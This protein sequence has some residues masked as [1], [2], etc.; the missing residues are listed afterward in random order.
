MIKKFQYKEDYKFTYHNLET[1]HRTRIYFGKCSKKEAVERANFIL[2]HYRNKETYFINPHNNNYVVLATLE[3]SSY[4]KTING[5][6]PEEFKTEYDT[7][8][9]MLLCSIFNFF[10]PTSNHYTPTQNKHKNVKYHKD[11][12][13]KIEK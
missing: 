4:R 10:D 2:H 1:N 8:L 3:S 6:R 13:G 9:E 11:Y 5:L 7:L 12:Y